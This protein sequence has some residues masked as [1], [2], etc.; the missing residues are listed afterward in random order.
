MSRYLGEALRG[1][2]GGVARAGAVVAGLLTT[3]LGFLSGR[4]ADVA[5]TPRAGP[6][7]SR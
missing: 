1:D 5:A 2:L 4:A 3:T 6:D 7:L